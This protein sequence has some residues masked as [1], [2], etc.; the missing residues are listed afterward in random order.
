MHRLRAVGRQVAQASPHCL[1][2]RYIFYLKEAISSKQAVGRQVAQPP[3]HYNIVHT[4]VH[5][6]NRLYWVLGLL[7]GVFGVSRT[8]VG[9]EEVGVR[10]TTPCYNIVHT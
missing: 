2:S 8:C 4:K 10:R 1:K 7:L 9:G 3:P 6:G 5:Q